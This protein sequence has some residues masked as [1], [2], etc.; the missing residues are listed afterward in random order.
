MLWYSRPRIVATAAPGTLMMAAVATPT[1]AK[2]RPAAGEGDVTPPVAGGC[3]CC[4]DSGRLRLLLLLLILLLLLLLLLLFHCSAGGEK[5][6]R[7][8]NDM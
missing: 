7:R 6:N 1:T 8:D 4:F 3:C 5:C 2:L